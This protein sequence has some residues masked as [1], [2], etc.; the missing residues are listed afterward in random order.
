MEDYA[1]VKT[2]GK[3]YRVRQGD[4]IRVESLPA[5]RGDVVELS[6]V[7]MASKGDDVLIGSP[8]LPGARVI[9][10]V[11]DR[12]KDKKIIVFTFKAKTRNRKK[13]GHRQHYTDLKVTG[14]QLG[15]ESTNE[16]SDDG[17]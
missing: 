3:Q 4:V 13:N 17:A 9:T 6:E 11:V 2:G 12:G 15:E 1:I 10:E 7:L 5:Y 8:T 16:G 14:I